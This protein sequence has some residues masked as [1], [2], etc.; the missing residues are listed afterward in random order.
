MICYEVNGIQL[1]MYVNDNRGLLLT[2][3]SNAGELGGSL[4][5][6]VSNAF[7]IFTVIY[8]LPF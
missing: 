5:S 2:E 1:H 3:S 7:F 6:I 8:W 4:G